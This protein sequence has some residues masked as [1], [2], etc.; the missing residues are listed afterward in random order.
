M[1]RAAALGAFYFFVV[2]PIVSFVLLSGWPLIGLPVVDTTMWGGL[3]VTIVVSVVGIVVSLPVGIVLAL[4]TPL[5]NAVGKTAF[6][7]VH[8]VRARRAADHGA[9]HGER[10][11]AAVRAAGMVARQIAARAGWH[12]GVRAAYQAEVVRAGLEAIPRGQYEAARALGLGYWRM[13]RLIVLPQALRIT[14]PEHRQQFHRVVQGHDAGVLC[15]HLR[16]SQDDR[17]GAQRS[18]NGRRR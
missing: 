8:R 18:R 3:L 17:G 6:R 11:A 12:C 14:I 10:H 5:G 1:R 15:R 9:V 4:G 2:L 7:R 16:F 13:N